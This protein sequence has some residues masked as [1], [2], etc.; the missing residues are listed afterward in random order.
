[1]RSSGSDTT[2]TYRY[3]HAP[4][5]AGLEA[6][7]G[8]YTL[9]LYSTFDANGLSNPVDV[10]A[11]DRWE[12]LDRNTA[13]SGP[14]LATEAEAEAG[15]SEV[16]KSFTPKLIK[17]AIGALTPSAPLPAQLVPTVGPVNGVLTKTNTGSVFAPLPHSPTL[18]T[19]H[20]GTATGL[21]LTNLTSARTNPFAAFS[22]AFDLDN[23][24]GGFLEVILNLTIATRSS[25]TIGFDTNGDNTARAQDAVFISALSALQTLD[26][27][28]GIAA[29][30]SVKVDTI[31]LYVSTTKVGD[32]VL[33]IGKN[34]N[35]EVGYL[36]TYT[37]VASHGQTG[38]CAMNAVLRVGYLPGEASE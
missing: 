24:E 25:T 11:A 19:V 5:S 27:S 12:R 38:N 2:T 22:P 31:P 37:A 21:S 17:D 34:A 28:G 35:N 23:E 18:R 13:T 3:V 7:L 14:P 30:E 20:D 32:I 26:V 1:M 33:H 10:H 15:T 6:A 9:R 36:L 29:N 4:G 16:V 8:G